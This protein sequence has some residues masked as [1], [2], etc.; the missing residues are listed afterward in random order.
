MLDQLE[1]KYVTGSLQNLKFKN[2]E[3][4][5]V[6]YSEDLT[7]YSTIRTVAF[8]DVVIV[9][10]VKALQEVITVFNKEAIEYQVIGLGA[11]LL[12]PERSKKVSVKLAFEFDKKYLDCVH[13]IYTLPASVPLSILSSHAIRNGIN[14]WQVFTGIPATLGGAV[15]MNAG[16]SLGEICEIVEEVK[17]LTKAG[18]IKTYRG[19]EL[20][21]GY[22]KNYFIKNGE[23]VIEVKLK[24]NGVKSE[25]SQQIRDYLEMRNKTQPLKEKTCGCV[26]KNI[27]SNEKQNGLV[28][29]AAGQTLDIIGLKGLTYQNV[30]ISPVHA[31]FMENFNNASFEE[32]RTLIRLAQKIAYMQT[33]LR[34]EPEV[35][36]LGEKN[37]N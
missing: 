11:N 28:T 7:K 22:R 13:D 3:S 30:R 4:I 2:S 17:L 26:F 14:G 6:R 37:K 35:Q 10:T 1:E 9:K 21:F 23:I 31:N 20:K 24:H 16:T 25:V 32:V 34:L 5:D 27:K 15:Y 19:E 8:G 12:L 29:C 36:I 18:D 33:G